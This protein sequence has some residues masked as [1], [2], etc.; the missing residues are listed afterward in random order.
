[1]GVENLLPVLAE[2]GHLATA[3]QI[4]QQPDYPGW[5]YMNSRGAT[6]V[7]ERWDGIRTDGSLQDVGMNSFN[8]YGLGSVGDWL[9]RTVGGV[10]AAAPGYRQVL[11]APKPGG[12][13]TSATAALQTRYGQTRSEW[14][15]TGSALTLKVVVPPNTTAIVQVPGNTVTAPPEAVPQ[16]AA[17]YS[18]PSGSYTFTAG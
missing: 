8:H 14:T 15:R 11:I 18:L 9:Y 3:Y 7:W 10:A 16:G 17:S 4:L 12:T 1:M 6:T 13:V 2:H 5:G